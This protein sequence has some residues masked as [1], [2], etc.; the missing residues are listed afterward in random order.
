V[1]ERA[2]E[3]GVD[4]PLSAQ[5]NDHQAPVRVLGDHLADPRAR[6]RVPPPRLPDDVAGIG[7]EGAQR[8]LDVAARD[9]DSNS[10]NGRPSRAQSVRASVVLPAPGA[11]AT[12]MR[13]TG[14]TGSGSRG[15]R[16]L[17]AGGRAADTGKP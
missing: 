5:P 10:T 7:E 17:I 12:A 4:L 3:P 1:R 13:R 9:R 11:P 16:T 14:S 8:R 15:P 2:A 6:H